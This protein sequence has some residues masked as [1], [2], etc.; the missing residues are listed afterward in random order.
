MRGVAGMSH[1]L[2]FVVSQK[3][4]PNCLM[5]LGRS[6]ALFARCA[7]RE[8]GAKRVTSRLDGGTRQKDVTRNLRIVNARVTFKGGEVRS[9]HL[10]PWRMVPG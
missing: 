3:K 10:Q 7:G 4:A 6:E 1:L 9:I 5:Q 8:S 2:D